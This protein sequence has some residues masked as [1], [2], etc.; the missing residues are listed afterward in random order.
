MIVLGLSGFVLF[1]VSAAALA[2]PEKFLE[3]I[4]ENVWYSH[5]NPHQRTLIQENL[6][7]CG[8][9]EV[10]NDTLPAEDDC[11]SFQPFCN[12]T[13]LEDVS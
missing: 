8:F 2:A 1:A 3:S 6:N 10:I 5:L 11:K 4:F 12:T 7:C 9:K 13:V